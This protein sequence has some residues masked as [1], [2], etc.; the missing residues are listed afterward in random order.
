MFELLRRADPTK[1]AKPVVRAYATLQGDVE[2]ADDGAFADIDTLEEYERAIRIFD[3]D[4][5]H[6]ERNAKHSR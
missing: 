2:I 3:G 6:V 1:G 5:G 4:D